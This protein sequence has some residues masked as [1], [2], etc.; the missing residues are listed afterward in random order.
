MNITGIIA[1]YN[2]FHNGHKYH[3]EEARRITGADYIVV[4][5]SGNFV[6]RGEPAIADKRL[7]T[8]AALQN[9]ADLVLELP[10]FHATGSAEYFAAGAAALLD[11]LGV[12]NALCFGSECNDISRLASVAS[13][14][15]REPEGYRLRLQEE[16]KKGHSFPRARSLALEACL[17]GPRT[18]MAGQALH[19]SPNNIL[20][21]E[22]IK[23]L[24]GLGSSIVPYTIKRIGCGYHDLTL[25][26]GEAYVSASALRRHILGPGPIAHIRPYV[27]PS[28]FSLLENALHRGF[29]VC[30]EDFSSL[31]HYKLL[32]EAPMGFCRYFDVTPDLSDKISRNLFRFSGY[33][34]FCGL[35]KSRDITYSRLSRSLLHILLGMTR[36]QMESYG[37]HGF[38]AYA[39]MLG[40]RRSAAPLL[41]AIKTHADVPLVSKLS[42]ARRCL[43]PMGL[44]ML[45]QDI[46]AA[47]IYQ[48]VAS[49]KFHGPFMNEYA[50]P[51]VIFD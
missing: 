30:R 31:L 41:K 38:I 32:S 49:A 15:A 25:P 28:V 36:E 10:L 9:G 51:L 29:P 16:L 26:S 47:H 27:P 35:L 6:Q 33:G 2:P 8:A 44:A 22:Y 1:E 21:I 13:L 42:H 4:V 14:L 23:S 45:E 34:Q 40:F 20:G 24:L 39:R 48:S 12:V 37:S 18:G 5:M 19:S 43:S 46:Q 17:N 7:R 11:R 3:L 50:R